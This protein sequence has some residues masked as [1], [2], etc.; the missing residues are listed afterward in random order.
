MIKRLQKHPSLEAVIEA[1]TLYCLNSVSWR[2]LLE[3]TFDG[4][5]RREGS[6]EDVATTQEAVPQI[7]PNQAWR[8]F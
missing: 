4:R 1:S 7:M 2:A 3:I 6:N 8:H 5:I